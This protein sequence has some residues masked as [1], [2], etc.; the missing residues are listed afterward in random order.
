MVRFQPVLREHS[1][2][3]LDTEAVAESVDVHDDYCSRRSSSADDKT[4]TAAFRMPFARSSSATPRFSTRTSSTSAWRE[5][6]GRDPAARSTASTQLRI[7]A[8][9]VQQSTHLATRLD[10]RVPVLLTT[11]PGKPDR[12]STRR[13]FELPRCRHDPK[14]PRAG[15][16][17]SER[18]RTVQYGVPRLLEGEAFSSLA[19]WIGA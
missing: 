1:A 13:L 14:S 9:F 4:L 12:P 3:R 16:P 18:L 10:H 2:D 17:P 15:S 7:V 19:G 6:A 8:G 11:I 5:S